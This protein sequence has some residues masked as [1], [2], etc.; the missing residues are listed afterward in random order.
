M[1]CCRDNVI[2]R[3]SGGQVGGKRLGGGC[4]G[5]GREVGGEEV[6]FTFGEVDPQVVQLV[7]G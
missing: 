2:E 1:V 7:S 3:E 6:S 4:R 5:D